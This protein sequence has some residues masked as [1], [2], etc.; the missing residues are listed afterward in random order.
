MSD[1]EPE[2]A[3]YVA[4]N[5]SWVANAPESFALM[6]KIGPRV[7]ITT[8]SHP[9]FLGFQADVQ[10][11]ILPL[12]GRYG[13]AKLRME[14]ELN[15]IRIYQYTMWRHWQDHDDFHREH[16]DRVFEL[17][18]SCLSMVIQGPW[19]PVFRLVRSRMNPTAGREDAGY[20][21]RSRCVAIAEHTV[22]PGAEAAFEAGVA[23]T[24][25]AVGNSAGF[26]G[27]MVLKQI[28]VSALGSFMLDPHSMG[29]ALQTLGGHPPKAPKPL[30]ETTEAV[31]NPPEYLVHSEWDSPDAA[32]LGLAKVLV[33]HGIRRMHDDAVL[34]HLIRGP[35]VLL[36]QP[37]MEEPSWRDA[38]V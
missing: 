30:F 22:R 16:F 1:R 4:L 2:S 36:F 13:G 18:A 31:P 15:P 24:M 29:E 33:N 38:I 6:E 23:E 10:S 35:Y 19:E 28:G 8:A 32:Q 21:P 11:G 25:D 27:Y 12:A 14:R 3:I 5:M 17:C 37:M 9:G 26:Q 34:A 20:R 7:C